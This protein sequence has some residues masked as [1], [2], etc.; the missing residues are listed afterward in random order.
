MA[1]NNEFTFNCS[2]PKTS[3]SGCMPL[4]PLLQFSESATV[5]K[6]TSLFRCQLA[7]QDSKK[8]T[9]QRVIFRTMNRIFVVGCWSF[10]ISVIIFRLFDSSA[11]YVDSYSRPG[12]SLSEFELNL[13]GRS[14]EYW[15]LISCFRSPSSGLWP[16]LSVFQCH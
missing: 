9:V 16:P 11:V 5:K 13:R 6:K 2:R 14:F 1:S 3:A 10:S 8:E 12:L 15:L 7:K 4:A